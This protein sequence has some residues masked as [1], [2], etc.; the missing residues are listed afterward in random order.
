MILKKNFLILRTLFFLSALVPFLT[1]QADIRAN[2]VSVINESEQL[3]FDH[4]PNI[5]KVFSGARD[6]TQKSEQIENCKAWIE[7]NSKQFDTQKIFKYW[8][9]EKADPILRQYIITGHILLKNW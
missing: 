5:Y 1:A 4:I 3:T 9:S 7:E 2:D 8:C 6:K